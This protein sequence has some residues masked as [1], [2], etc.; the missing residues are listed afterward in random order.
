MDSKREKAGHF[1][2][3]HP[4]VVAFSALVIGLGLTVPVSAID[5]LKSVVEAVDGV[6]GSSGAL[7]NREI[8]DGVVEALRVDTERVVVQVSA[9]DGYNLDPDIHIPLAGALNAAQK[10]LNSVSMA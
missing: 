10:V 9:T 8:G 6:G 5:F 7:N 3:Q 2:R 4:M 1:R